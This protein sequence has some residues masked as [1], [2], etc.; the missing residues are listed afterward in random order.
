MVLFREFKDE[1]ARYFD[2]GF[3][4]HARVGIELMPGVLLEILVAYKV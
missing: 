4:A 3:P 2:Q 1:Y